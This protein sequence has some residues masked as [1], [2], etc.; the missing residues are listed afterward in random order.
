MDNEQI[1]SSETEHEKNSLSRSHKNVLFFI[2][3]A[4]ISLLAFSIYTAHSANR[5]KPSNVVVTLS[6]IFALL[7]GCLYSLNKTRRITLKHI[8]FFLVWIVVLIPF[9][10]AFDFFNTAT[11]FFFYMLLQVI[12]GLAFLV[13][14]S[15]T[16]K[17]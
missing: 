5:F 12:A 4:F 11:F 17:R 9:F 1:N 8:L 14:L 7:A 3:V 16:Q 2:T 15:R 6:L 13:M 10:A